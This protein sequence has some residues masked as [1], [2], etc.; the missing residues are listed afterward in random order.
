MY[1][2]VPFHSQPVSAQ[3]C[4]PGLPEQIDLMFPEWQPKV[5]MHKLRKTKLKKLAENHRS[6][7]APAS[8]L[9]QY[10]GECNQM[11]IKKGNKISV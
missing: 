10:K 4:P 7:T 11:K 9:G 3:K 1:L 2:Q 8:S 5:T 6:A